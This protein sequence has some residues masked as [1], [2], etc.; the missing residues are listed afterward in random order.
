MLGF[1]ST[2]RSRGANHVAG[3]HSQGQLALCSNYIILTIHVDH[4]T[5]SE[6]AAAHERRGQG[7]QEI[8]LSIGEPGE[9][10][11]HSGTGVNHSAC[12]KGGGSELI[13][14]LGNQLAI[15]Q[16]VA[17]IECHPGTGSILLVELHAIGHGRGVALAAVHLVHVG[18]GAFHGSAGAGLMAGGGSQAGEPTGLDS[19]A[20]IQL[21]H[22]RLVGISQVTQLH[23][24]IH[25][26][27]GSGKCITNG[28]NITQ[29][30]ST[31]IQTQAHVTTNVQVGG[32]QGALHHVD[33]AVGF[34]VCS[35]RDRSH[36]RMSCAVA[37]KAQ[38]TFIG[39]LEGLNMSLPLDGYLCALVVINDVGLAGS[40]ASA[41]DLQGL[42]VGIASDF[43][44]G[45]LVLIRVEITGIHLHGLNEDVAFDCNIGAL[46]HI[47]RTEV[48][49]S[50]S[51][52]ATAVGV[53][54]GHADDG[55]V[56]IQLSCICTV[57]QVVH[58]AE[59]GSRLRFTGHSV[60]LGEVDGVATVDGGGVAHLHIGVG[61]GGLAAGQGIGITHP[62]VA[63]A[64]STFSDDGGIVSLAAI[65]SDGGGVLH[66]H[67]E[68][69]DIHI[70]SD[71]AADNIQRTLADGDIRA[72]NGAAGDEAG[73]RS[74]KD[75]LG[76][77]F[78]CV[79]LVIGAGH[80]S[81]GNCGVGKSQTAGIRL[82]GGSRDIGTCYLNIALTRHD[83]GDI[84]R[85]IG[86]GQSTSIRHDGRSRDIGTCYL[87]IALTRHDG[88]SRNLAIFH[89]YGTFTSGDDG[90][91]YL[92]TCDTQRA[93]TRG[94]GGISNNG[95]IDGSRSSNYYTVGG[96]GN[97]R[98]FDV[99]GNQ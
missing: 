66:S 55:V 38:N 50:I 73:G 78:R 12:G 93:V 63:F 60:D 40:F 21:C 76:I 6:R 74:G 27:S 51:T 56:D 71:G 97:L 54:G 87:N 90:V 86:D 19:G 83:G 45:K 29:N 7:C 22:T 8:V 53:N 47:H 16:G 79:T 58:R 3:I 98:C 18:L 99:V 61:D 88:G 95:I 68:G 59:G 44:R 20:C 43:Y 23:M 65:Q 32:G 13:V 24:S 80:C 67:A 4:V 96:L 10:L 81:G 15:L 49:G 91:G 72:G 31:A 2:Q 57:A 37:N 46:L 26:C 52:I 9:S 42:D 11:V 17:R 25:R 5:G 85:G 48:P 30:D 28:C 33:N 94:D 35:R 39:E 92:Y 14:E 75:A 82:D 62:Q 69:G 84:N 70:T 89:C 41:A 77:L 1:H 36:G 64:A 34:G